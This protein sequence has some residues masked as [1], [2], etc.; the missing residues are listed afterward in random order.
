MREISRDDLVRVT[1]CGTDRSAQGL[2][3]RYL[4]SRLSSRFFY[5]EL[6]DR[7]VIGDAAR[8]YE[9]DI[10]LRGAFVRAVNASGMSDEEKAAV[11]RCGLAALDGRMDD[12]FPREGDDAK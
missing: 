8:D 1:V 3:L 12:T 11:L 7:R 2:D 10:S 4:S 5:A 6:A 9:T